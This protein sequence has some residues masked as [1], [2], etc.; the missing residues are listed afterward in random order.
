MKTKATEA[1]KY[2][3]SVSYFEDTKYSSDDANEVVRVAEAIRAT[4]LAELE[5]LQ[6]VYGNYSQ[7]EAIH[8]K[9]R[10]LQAKLN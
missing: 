2:I 1:V 3:E 6:W 5:V 9:I 7:D 10:N 4:Q 8:N